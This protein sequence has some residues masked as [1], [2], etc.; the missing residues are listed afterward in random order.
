VAKPTRN[1]ASAAQ[2]GRRWPSLRRSIGPAFTMVEL[3]SNALTGVGAD[4][5]VRSQSVNGSWAALANAATRKSAAATSSAWPQPL[6][7]GLL[8]HI[9]IYAEA[10]R[11]EAV[12]TST[13]T[14]A[15]MAEDEGGQ[16][17]GMPPARLPSPTNP[18]SSSSR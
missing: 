16:S 5:A 11:R 1:A 14:I 8:W 4:I 12:P 3:W 7:N 2:C 9:A 15:L 17:Q 6:I 18:I 10:T 13:A